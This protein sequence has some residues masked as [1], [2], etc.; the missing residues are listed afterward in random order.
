MLLAL[1]YSRWNE[2]WTHQARTSKMV[3]WNG[4]KTGLCFSECVELFKLDSFYELYRICRQRNYLTLTHHEESFG[5]HFTWSFSCC[6][7]RYNRIR[8]CEIHAAIIFSDCGHAYNLYR[9]AGKKADILRARNAYLYAFKRTSHNERS[10]PMPL[11][12]TTFYRL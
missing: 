6:N 4:K 12:P 5:T 11:I 10:L 9:R 2:Q 8:D 3:T 7:V 1:I